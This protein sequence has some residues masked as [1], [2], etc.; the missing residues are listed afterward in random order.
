MFQM[1]ALRPERVFL[2]SQPAVFSGFSAQELGV[3]ALTLADLPRAPR[4]PWLRA[5]AEAAGAGRSARGLCGEGMERRKAS[6][7]GEFG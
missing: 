7:L 6:F 2:G 1:F 3:T 4:L 5:K